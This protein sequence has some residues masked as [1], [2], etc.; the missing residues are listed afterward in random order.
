M[1]KLG[2]NDN[3]GNLPYIGTISSFS[4]LE[5]IVSNSQLTVELTGWI[6]VPNTGEYKFK[7]IHNGGVIFDFLLNDQLNT[8]YMTILNNPNQGIDETKIINLESNNLYQIKIRISN[9]NSQLFNFDMEMNNNKMDFNSFYSSPT[10]YYNN[11]NYTIYIQFILYI[12]LF[13]LGI[14]SVLLYRCTKYGNSSL[15]NIRFI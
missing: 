2:T 11:N 12:T 13:I 10:S 3:Y 14:F 15:W 7:V 8:K 9:T 1:Y 4:E 6:N 5:Q